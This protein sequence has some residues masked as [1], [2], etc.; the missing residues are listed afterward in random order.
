VGV[1]AGRLI[2]LLLLAGAYVPL[3]R[4][5]VPDRA[6]PAGISTRAA[7][8][9]AWGVG[10]YGTLVVVGLAFALSVLVPSGRVARPAEAAAARLA[11]PRRAA[12][13]LGVALL[14]GGLALAIAIALFGGLPTSVDEMAQ[15]LHARAVASGQLTI[16]VPG[17]AAA[18]V[19]QNGVVTADGWASIYPPLHTLLLALGLL[20]G[21]SWLVGPLAVAVATGVSALVFEELLGVGPGRVAALVLA[22]SPFWLLLGATHLS[23]TSAAAALA[24]VLWTGLRARD[25]GIGWAVASGAAVGAAVTARPWTGLVASA[26]L[27]G[28]VW[29]P[30]RGRIV[31]RLAGMMAGGLPFAALLFWWNWR[32]FGGPLRLGYSAAFGPAHGLGLHPDPW[33][34]LYGAREALAYT[35]ADVVQLG[36]HLLETPLPATALIGVALLL[37]MRTGGASPLLAWVVAALAGNALY[38]HHGVHMGPRMLYEAVPAWTGLLVAAGAWLTSERAARPRLRRGAAWSL[39]VAGAGALALAPGVVSQAARTEG[40]AAYVTVPDPGEDGTALVFVHGSWSSRV[41]ARLVDAGMRRDSVETALRRNDACAADRYARWRATDV[42]QRAAEAPTLDLDPL[43]GTPPGLRRVGLS[44]GN[45]VW[46]EP[47]APRDQ[48]CLREAAADRN[49]VVELEP[50][51]WQAPPLSGRDV[52]VAR[53]M[54]PPMNEVVT[55]ALGGPVAFVYAPTSVDD[56][57]PRLMEYEEGMRVLWGAE[58]R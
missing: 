25:G 42:A 41:A 20:S 6:G 21:A 53:D 7:A 16:P 5:L 49:G 15:L 3:H 57:M 17:T 56:P 30:A 28:A 48:A 23:H 40:N 14:A 19:I 58:G 45:E 11:R 27:L 35:G 9:A 44:P 34:N 4:L 18:W 38:W 10:L 31:S 22:V 51:L 32:L 26:A 54:G 1:T 24:L 50:L 39:V 13:A 12:F 33:G 8:E 36:A 2:G 46:I 43:P 47:T 29:W 37:G 52:V 55:A